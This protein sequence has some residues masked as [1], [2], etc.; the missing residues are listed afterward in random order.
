[1]HYAILCYDS[2]AVVSS[3]TKEEDDAAMVKLA[4]VQKKLASE[5]KLGPVARLKPTK[6]AKTL[7]KGEAA[8]LVDGPFAETK[9][10]LLGFFIVDCATFEDAVEAA[11]E[12]AAASSTKG[13]YE[14]RPLLMFAPTPVAT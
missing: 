10:V 8:M 6:T 14:I 1:M 13:A 4:A 3:W 2:E 7:R 12:L 9:E 5:G 11:R